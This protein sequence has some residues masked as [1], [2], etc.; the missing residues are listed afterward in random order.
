MRSKNKY[1]FFEKYK[2]PAYR[3]EWESLKN[4][5]ENSGK[6]KIKKKSKSFVAS[7]KLIG[8]WP[9]LARVQD[10]YF[11][12]GRLF[13]QQAV[14]LTDDE[15]IKIFNLTEVIRNNLSHYIPK[16]FAFSVDDIIENSQPF[17]KAIE[18]LVFESFSIFPRNMKQSQQRVRNAIDIIKTTLDKM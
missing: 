13:G 10:S 7:E 12:M 3:I 5:S 17:L 1:I 14:V 9:A 6:T 4:I 11:W 8:F 16:I 18:F 2:T 15:L